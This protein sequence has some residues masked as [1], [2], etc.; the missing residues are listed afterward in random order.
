MDSADKTD[1]REVARRAGI[2]LDLLDSN[3]ELTYEQRALRHREALGKVMAY[4][5][6]GGIKLP[7]NVIIRRTRSG[8][9]LL[10]KVNDGYNVQSI[11]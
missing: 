4:E 11:T 2:D 3:L 8:V 1:A 5:E 10:L 6:T 7:E 9:E